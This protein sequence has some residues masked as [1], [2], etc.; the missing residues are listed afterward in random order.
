MDMKKL[1]TTC[2]LLLAA[3][4]TLPTTAQTYM[5][6][7][8]GTRDAGYAFGN[9]RE[10]GLCVRIPSGKAAYL[11]GAK[12][13][14][15]R[16][17]FRTLQINSLDLFITKDLTAEEL[18]VQ[19]MGQSSN[20]W[21]DYTLEKPFEIDGEEF[22][23]GYIV[24]ASNT[25]ARPL[26]FDGSTDVGHEAFWVIED[27]V[28]KDASE[29]GMGAANIQMILEGAPTVADLVMKRLNASGVYKTGNAYSFKGQVFNFGTDTIHSLE[30]TLQVGEAEPV[31]FTR[32]VQL[33]PTHTYDVTSPAYR[34]QGEGRQ[35]VT[36][37]VRPG[38]EGV[39]D[40]DE[41][42]NTASYE[43]GVLSG[44]IKKKVLVEGFSTQGCG[45]CP[46][47]HDALE[48]ALAKSPEDF[49]QIFHHSAF[50]LDR[51]SMVDDYMFLWFFAD[52]GSYAPATMFNRTKIFDGGQSPLFVP[53]YEDCIT[54]VNQMLAK[55][56]PLT[57][58]LE[59][60]FNP[61]T[62]TGTVT[63]HIETFADPSARQHY[64]TVSLTQDSI[65]G[66][67][68]D[69]TNGNQRNYAHNAVYRGSFTN[70]MGDPIDLVPGET[71]TYTY[72]YLIEE[73]ITSTYGNE[74]YGSRVVPTDPRNMHIVAFVHDYESG[75]ATACTVYN[76]ETIPVY[77]DVTGMREVNTRPATAPRVYDLQGRRVQ[78]AQK[79]LYIVN[80]RKLYI[81]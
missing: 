51:F 64:L 28:W 62:G 29:A 10:Q 71:V 22:Y 56:A 21:T 53:T 17:V 4:G 34:L 3:L 9:S 66:Y 12:V 80:G 37:T 8:D 73:A 81:R 74:T 15:L 2:L 69:Y 11:K 55:D 5:G 75:Q 63:V 76:A 57:I 27:G 23:I 78:Q 50:G 40:A 1:Q 77:V 45:N 19:D 7:T 6:Y 67:Q 35:N 52:A 54:A 46:D 41:S 42:D 32:R 70:Y 18:Y 33:D 44:D 24:Q 79:G 72:P 48:M 47:G 59:N 13:T 31:T 16:T 49:I 65:Y 61:E 30:F 20:L 36:I 38:D 25:M 43:I 58:D 60:D 14:G 68:A 39:E 26:A